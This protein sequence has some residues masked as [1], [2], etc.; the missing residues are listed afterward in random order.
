V[1]KT[2]ITAWIGETDD[3]STSDS[4]LQEIIFCN[5]EEVEAKLRAF[6]ENNK[7]INV[8]FISDLPSLDLKNLIIRSNGLENVRGFRLRNIYTSGKFLD[9]VRVYFK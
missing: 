1:A 3:V 7:G 9:S 6:L 2:I 8:H 5:R 4:Y